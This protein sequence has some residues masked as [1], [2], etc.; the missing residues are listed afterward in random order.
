MSTNAKSKSKSGSTSTRARKTT[1]SAEE[2]RTEDTTA[3]PA[4]TSGPAPRG[5]NDIR[6]DSAPVLGHAVEVVEGEHQGT[7]GTFESLE[8]DQAVITPRSAPQSRVTVPVES[9]RPADVN[10]R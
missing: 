2:G 10:R 9:L 8:G 3:V 5:L 7:F 6:G 4:P 1:R